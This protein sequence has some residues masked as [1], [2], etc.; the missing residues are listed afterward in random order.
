M[1]VFKTI[2][3]IDDYVTKNIVVGKIVIFMTDI[4]TKT[5]TV[6]DSKTD[7]KT[8]IAL[9]GNISSGKTTLC[10]A[11]DE[12]TIPVTILYEP[13]V[14]SLLQLFYQNKA[15]YAFA[16][17][18]FMFS[19]RYDAMERMM[20]MSNTTSVLDRSVFGDI[21]FAM[22]QCLDGHMNHHEWKCYMDVLQGKNW[23]KWLHKLTIVYL[24]TEPKR[25]RAS[26]QQRQQ[27]DQVV[28]EDY[29]DDIDHLHIYGLLHIYTLL[30]KRAIVLNWQ[31]FGNA[32]DFWKAVDRTKTVA[33][34]D[35]S[36]DDS[37]ATESIEIIV[38]DESDLVTIRDDALP[39]CKGVERRIHNAQW[40]QK[41]VDAMIED[42][43][44]HVVDKGRAS[45]LYHVTRRLWHELM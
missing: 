5:E 32:Q 28:Q 31:S 30:Q 13:V 6:T 10:R 16:L 15:K 42:K 45:S 1:K 27:V 26:V 43:P 4:D 3:H 39:L 14:D 9:E 29:L 38:D 33:S 18:L 7:T 19:T 17:Q 37:K 20:A 11:L 23:L 35:E 8:I 40:K 41:L 2:V 34:H 22:K 24:H 44:I 36:S 21:V 25:C 12:S